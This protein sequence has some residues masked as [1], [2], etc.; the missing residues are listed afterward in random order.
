LVT[1]K[2]ELLLHDLTSPE[3]I[4]GPEKPDAD[5]ASLAGQRVARVE[6]PAD[7]NNVTEWARDAPYPSSRHGYLRGHGRPPI[8]QESLGGSR[9]VVVSCLVERRI[10]SEAWHIHDAAL[11][12]SFTFIGHRRDT[13]QTQIVHSCRAQT[14]LQSCISLHPPPGTQLIMG[15]QMR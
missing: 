9:P 5:V 1:R 7:D 8:I 6:G 13:N 12:M 15:E 3:A 2:G 10:R 11:P 4:V 14:V